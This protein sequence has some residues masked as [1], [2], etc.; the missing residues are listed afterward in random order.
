[1]HTMTFTI[2]TEVRSSTRSDSETVTSSQDERLLNPSILL[3]GAE[4]KTGLE[5]L[6]QLAEHPSRPYIHAF[7]EDSSKL[8]DEH[9]LRCTSV[10]EGSARHAVDIEEALEETSASWIVLSNG[11]DT[12]PKD[13]R[14]NINLRTL[15]AK[16][17]AFVLDLPQ[18]HSV[19]A[20]VV[21]RIGAAQSSSI[22]IG[23]RGRLCKIVNRVFHDFVGQEEALLPIRNR[24][25]VVRTTNVTE[26]LTS[27][28][29]RRLILNEND[30]A[31]SL[32][33]ERS[34][35]A[36]CIVDEILVQPRFY[37]SRVINVTSV[38]PQQTS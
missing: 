26:S 16:N 20:V 19:R 8:V 35:L 10:T 24:T 14:G 31:P 13:R 38:F 17:V 1:M 15:T 33:T 27:S 29:S 4:S 23:L 36:A 6:R 18:F 25:T 28:S 37:G 11:H 12:N 3:V 30:R 9:Y 34:D 22:K 7:V 32:F 2:P 5:I 21:S